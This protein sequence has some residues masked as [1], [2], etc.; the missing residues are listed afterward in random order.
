MDLLLYL[1]DAEYLKEA[2]IEESPVSIDGERGTPMNEKKTVAIIL[3]GGVGDRF[4]AQIP[5]QFLSLN[6]RPIIAHTVDAI[7]QHPRINDII[8]VS[9]ESWIGKTKELFPDLLVVSGGKTRQESSK[10]GLLACPA[11][12]D[13]V[14]I[15]DAVRP[16]IS[17][18]VLERCFSALD[19]G[20]VAVD[21]VIH[22][23][24]T[25]V[26]IDN[27][28]I[29]SMP[30]RSV[31]RRAQTPQAFKF[32]VIKEAHENTSLSGSTDDIRLV[33]ESG[34]KCAAVD[35]DPLNMKVTTIAD[36]YSIERLS[37]FV[38]P[39]ISSYLDFM[40]KTAV[41]FG[42]TSGIGAETANLL[43]EN[44]AK[45]FRCGRK[46]CD[47]RNPEAVEN[48]FKSLGQVDIVVN[49]AG[50]LIAHTIADANESIV[51][52][53]IETNL[54]GPINVC[55]VAVRYMKSGGHIVN[56]GSSS[57]YLGREGFSTYSASKAGLA[58]FSQAAAAEFAKYG[59][60]V[61]VVSP[62]KTNTS[63][64]LELNPNPDYSTLFDPKDA[65]RIICSYCTGPETGNIVDL[66][67]HMSGFGTGEN[68]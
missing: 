6:G 60:C 20:Y 27:D 61:N 32:S 36:L 18:E 46:E 25:I 21:T 15:H 33:F 37:Q 65:A 39:K 54:I 16:L 31:L 48:L 50:I 3:S 64:Y 30:D 12:T 9:N 2:G 57:A 53:V 13:Y 49:S 35:G 68:A 17:Y 26:Q 41:V 45:V 23:T 11:D 10:N 67:L 42:G 28:E 4:G 38:K 40:G 44:H 62:P 58:N 63:M 43:E 34:H 66:K 19:S 55:R 22:S 29:S 5:K 56:I 1:Q 59:I 47:V 24:D 8:I 7:R 52:D 51:N 14:F